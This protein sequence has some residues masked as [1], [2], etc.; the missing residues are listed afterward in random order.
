MEQKRNKV[1]PKHGKTLLKKLTSVWFYDEMYKQNLLFLIGLPDEA[2]K[3]IKKQYNID[4]EFS[5][6][7]AGKCFDIKHYGLIIWLESFIGK[8]K[9]YGVLLHEIFHAALFTMD[10]IKQEV[11]AE[12]EVVAYY[13]EYLMRKFLELG[14][15]HRK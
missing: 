15:P 2:V 4:I 9:E 12:N 5:G 7:E 3:Y 13:G 14:K 10:N 11:T 6:F 8:P 1:S